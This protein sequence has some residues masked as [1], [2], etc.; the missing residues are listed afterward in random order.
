MPPIFLSI[1][2]A[3]GVKSVAELRIYAAE[4]PSV[5]V[6]GQRHVWFMRVF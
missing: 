5:A 1:Q 2:T 3:V 4:E 6:T